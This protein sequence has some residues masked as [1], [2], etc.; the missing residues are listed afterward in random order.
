LQ[1]GQIAEANLYNALLPDYSP[2][3]VGQ[4]AAFDAAKLMDGNDCSSRAVAKGNGHY[5]WS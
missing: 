3:P 1:S 2:S 4:R 5:N